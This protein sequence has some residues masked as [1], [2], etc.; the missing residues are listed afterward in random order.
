MKI[1]IDKSKIFTIVLSVFTITLLI[2]LELKAYPP[3]RNIPVDIKGLEGE[4]VH[5]DMPN[6]YKA[7]ISNSNVQ[8]D[9]S[10]LSL[11]KVGTSEI[12][13]KDG[14]RKYNI[15][16]TVDQLPGTRIA[17]YDHNGEPFTKFK[18]V[19]SSTD[20][21]HTIQTL[22]TNEIV[23]PDTV[24][25]NTQTVAM[26][27]DKT[28]NDSIYLV[29]IKHKPAEVAVDENKEEDGEDAEEST[30]TPN[31]SVITIGDLIIEPIEGATYIKNNRVYVKEEITNRPF[32]TDTTKVE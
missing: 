5:I 25:D 18:T 17:I 9:G 8:L 31:P 20:G 19:F 14:L 23:I 32:D 30:P 29:N 26:F 16:I 2:L 24:K 11:Y 15:K 6:S 22:W 4:I 21:T 7:T 28:M 1:K 27:K 12:N 3:K 10:E 13:I